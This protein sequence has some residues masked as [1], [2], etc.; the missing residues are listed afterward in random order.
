MP[1]DGVVMACSL[2]KAALNS[3]IGGVRQYFCEYLGAKKLAQAINA[4]SVSAT[5]KLLL[6][7]LAC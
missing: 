3:S 4:L 7:C 2:A 5:Q 1:N 6:I